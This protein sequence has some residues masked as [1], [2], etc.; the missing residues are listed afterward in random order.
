MEQHTSKSQISN[1]KFQIGQT[2]IELL[3]A[4][5]LATILLPAILTG[6]V[7]SSTG[8]AQQQERVKALGYM[9]EASE[10]VRNLRDSDWNNIATNGTYHPMLTS[11]CVTTS[12]TAWKLCS[13]PEVV[14][15]FTRSI[16]IADVSPSDPSLKQVTVTVSWNSVI[17]SNV[18]SIFY[19]ARWKNISYSP[20]TAGGSLTGQGYGDWCNPGSQI[21]G[22]PFSLGAI[23]IAISATVY[24]TYDLAYA[25]TGNNRSS[26]SP[27][28]GLNL[29]HTA[30]PTVTNPFSSTDNAKAYGM[31]ADSSNVY[32]TEANPGPTVR[33]AK[34]SDLSDLGVFNSN[35]ASNGPGS[36]YVS[37]VAGNAGATG[38]VTIGNTLFSF[39][40]SAIKGGN[41]SQTQLDSVSILGN[42]QRVLVLG[43]DA[44]V[45]TDSTT[46]QVQIVPILA[47]GKFD[48]NNIKNINLGNS[49][50]GVD[51]TFDS[52]GKFLYVITNYTPNQNDLFLISL[53]NTSSVYGYSTHIP[54][55]SNGAGD[56]NP[57]GIASV[58]LGKVIVVGCNGDNG[59]DKCPVQS[60]GSY[61]YQVFNVPTDPTQVTRCGGTT[62]VVNGTTI[63][64]I[65][66]I[67][68]VS[69]PDG[70]AY[71]YIIDGVNSSSQLQI[72]QGG[73]GG[74]GGGN[75]GTFE[76]ETFDCRVVTSGN[77]SACTAP[78]TFNKFN[79]M[80]N[81]TVPIPSPLNV[82]TNYQVAVSTDCSTFSYTGSY[83]SSGGPIPI[84]INPGYCFRYKVTFSN[85]GSATNASTS[86]QVNYSP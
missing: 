65:N 62:P 72:I 33:I 40:L 51:A 79:E 77:P 64:S 24:P 6:F 23:P 9:E 70:N 45:V 31:Y 38:F 52:Q 86:V 84:S 28:F 21:V 74:G 48:K 27:V 37:G 15:D 16:A 50:S 61:I 1:L 2:I 75:G 56:M 19:L 44:Y 34:A 43:S 66:A 71:S 35:P 68:G 49:Q 13:G 59:N 69:H 30:P 46:A 81:P 47:G 82:T 39:D 58:T 54:A 80:T 5:G 11:D 42:G 26:G 78:V 67:T 8:K 25:S 10:A 73:P 3:V 83:T 57:R 53:A 76:S 41:T 7:T 22:T 18:S 85:A 32:F 14:D 63:T 55:G 17:P 20:I 36:V 12:G 60:P 29:T 4:F